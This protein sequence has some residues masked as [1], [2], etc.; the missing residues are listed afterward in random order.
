MVGTAVISYIVMVIHRE[1][2]ACLPAGEENVFGELF[3]GLQ[4]VLLVAELIF[5]LLAVGSCV[6]FHPP[7]AGALGVF[8]KLL[9]LAVVSA[10]VLGIL[11]LVAGF[12]GAN[13]FPMSDDIRSFCY[14]LFS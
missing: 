7:M 1:Y 2:L 12:G 9:L 10:G 3:F 8:L 13:A 4:T 6:F 14:Y 11:W 5:G